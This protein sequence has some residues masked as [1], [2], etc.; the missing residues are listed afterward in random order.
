MKEKIDKHNL[1]KSKKGKVLVYASIFLFVGTVTTLLLLSLKNKG[2]SD[3]FA[4]NGSS[5][6]S[7]ASGFCKYGDEFPL[8]YGS[9]GK[10]VKVFQKVL[11]LKGADLGDGG[12]DG[13][14]GTKTQRAAQKYF[15]VAAIS[16]ALG[17]NLNIA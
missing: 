14:Y 9:C 1:L 8:K 16:S 6:S 10:N 17:K 4:E 11:Q 15:Q 3:Q 2:E 5:T 13:K 7:G 12:I